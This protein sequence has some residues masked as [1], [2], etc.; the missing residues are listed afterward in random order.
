MS[1]EDFVKYVIE[2]LKVNSLSD[3]KLYMLG[4]VLVLARSREDILDA[5]RAIGEPPYVPLSKVKELRSRRPSISHR[6]RDS[7][8]EIILSDLIS[9]EQAL[10]IANTLCSKLINYMPF[11]VRKI[12]VITTFRS[13]EDGGI[14]Q[15]YQVV[16]NLYRVSSEEFENI[17]KTVSNVINELFKE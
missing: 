7:D 3:V 12:D 9:H 4:N 5:F 17:S 15:R 13:S 6:R 1:S 11:K 14:F 16:I 10:L 8:V 2:V